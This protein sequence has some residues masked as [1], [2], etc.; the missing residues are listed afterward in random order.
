MYVATEV[1]PRFMGLQSPLCA[2]ENVSLVI[3]DTVL[4]GI[5]SRQTCFILECE[6]ESL[7]LAMTGY[8]EKLHHEWNFELR[9]MILT[10]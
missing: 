4:Y 9:D 8:E 3:L 5:E 2:A 6:L 10:L 7:L 1:R